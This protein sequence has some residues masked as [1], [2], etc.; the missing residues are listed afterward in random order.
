MRAEHVEARVGGLFARVRR[1]EPD[2]RVRDL[3]QP[4]VRHERRDQPVG[5]QREQI[6]DP[7]TRP[8]EQSLDAGRERRNHVAAPQA[9][10]ARPC[11]RHT[12]R[13]G[14]RERH[15]ASPAVAPSL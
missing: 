2:N 8:L 1:L 3:R 9:G 10:V 11:F 5:R 13:T 6:P 15:A 14:V 7:L 4:L 12:G